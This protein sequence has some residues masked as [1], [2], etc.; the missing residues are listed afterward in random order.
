MPWKVAKPVDLK[1]EFIARLKRGERMGDLCR[2][3]GIARS[4]QDE[5][6]LR[7]WSERSRKASPPATTANGPT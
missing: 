4:D 3:Y 1:L 7:S 5:L 2:E 6:S